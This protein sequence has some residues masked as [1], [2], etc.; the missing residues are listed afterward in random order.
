MLEKE[1]VCIFSYIACLRFMAKPELALEA[2][3][4]DST[5]KNSANPAITIIAPPIR[6]TVLKLCPFSP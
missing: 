1:K 4:P 6:H 5:P 3:F 2:S